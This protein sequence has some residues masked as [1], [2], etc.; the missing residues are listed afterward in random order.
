MLHPF[1][2]LQARDVG[3]I[4]AG[5]TTTAPS[6]GGPSCTG[7]PQR[8]FPVPFVPAELERAYVAL[9]SHHSPR[10]DLDL[11]HTLIDG[12]QS[13]ET[14]FQ[15][16][17]VS[18]W[19]IAGLFTFASGSLCLV[20]VEVAGARRNGMPFPSRLKAMLTNLQHCFE[21]R[22][23]TANNEYILTLSA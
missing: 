10:K 12:L 11:S 23:D 22:R 5:S 19:F 4:K 7:M 3:G 6:R 21:F 15:F 1:A 14:W 9:P 16:S 18:Y 13:T 8:M 17:H 2:R 20:G